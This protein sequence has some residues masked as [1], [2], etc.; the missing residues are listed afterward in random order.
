MPSAALQGIR[1]ADHITTVVSLKQTVDSG[2]VSLSVDNPCNADS[3]NLVENNIL[4]ANFL[5]VA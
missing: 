2:T 5:A 3:E 4:L 1:S